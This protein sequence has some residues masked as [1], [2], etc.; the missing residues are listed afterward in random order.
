MPTPIGVG[1]PL[2]GAKN[3]AGAPC[4]NRSMANG[5]CHMHGGKSEGPP[6]DNKNATTHGIY[7]IGLREDERP[8]WAHIELGSL[9]DELKLLRLQLRRA[10]GSQLQHELNPAE[11]SLLEITEI[12]DSSETKTAPGVILGPGGKQAGL[13]ET[14]TQGRQITRG[15]P[16]Y[17]RLVLSLTQRIADLEMKRRTLAADGGQQQ[18]PSIFVMTLNG[19]PTPKPS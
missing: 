11:P 16:D 10:V 1:R 6:L 3:R 15:R 4:A 13:A 17:R 9:D 14:K 19:A 12:S 5:R 2:C 18:V 7:T 8:L